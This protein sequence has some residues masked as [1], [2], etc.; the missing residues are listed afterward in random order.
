MSTIKDDGQV[1]VLVKVREDG[2]WAHL[3]SGIKTATSHPARVLALV[4]AAPED[5]PVGISM[6]G[7]VTGGLPL[8]SAAINGSMA[9]MSERRW[10]KRLGL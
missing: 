2:R 5:E 8:A 4:D 9:L 6:G 3:G 10:R 1:V 7:E